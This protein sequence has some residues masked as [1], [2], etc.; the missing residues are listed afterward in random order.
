M[1][2]GEQLRDSALHIQVSIV[3]Q[4]PHP[5][6]LTHTIEQ[7]FTI[8]LYYTVG[9]CWLSILCSSVYTVIQPVSSV[10]QS[11]LTL[12]DSMDC[13]MLACC[14]CPSPTSRDYSNSCPSSQWCHA[15]NSSS[16]VPFFSC[17]P[18]FPMSGSFLVSQFFI[19]GGQSI[20]VSAS[21]SVLP[22][23]IQDWFPLG[24]TGWISLQPSSV[25]TAIPNSLTIPF[26]TFPSPPQQP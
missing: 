3:P 10:A 19:S 17:L 25:Y 7:S 4:T 16:V 6:R 11:Y 12:C 9:P 14:P 23:N 26:P 13:S 5:S 22:M 1:V 15:T 18:S 24:L 21:A 2:S 20:G 8:Q